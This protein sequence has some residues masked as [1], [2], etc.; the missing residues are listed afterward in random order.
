MLPGEPYEDETFVE[1]PELTQPSSAAEYY[2]V[3]LQ[4]KIQGDTF[5]VLAKDRE[6]LAM[7]VQ[8]GDWDIDPRYARYD[9]DDEDYEDDKDK[10]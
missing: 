6:Q 2:Y 7:K 4:R 3:Y 9:P 10:K 1:L 5:R 8:R